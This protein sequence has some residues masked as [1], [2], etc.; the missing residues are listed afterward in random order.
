MDAMHYSEMAA[1]A[2]Q[3]LGITRIVRLSQRSKASV[4][5]YIT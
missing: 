4:I 1:M 5:V 2:F 3:V